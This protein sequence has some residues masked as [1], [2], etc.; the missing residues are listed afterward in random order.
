[1]VQFIHYKFNQLCPLNFVSFFFVKLI[2]LRINRNLSPQ[3]I[4][5]SLHLNRL[6][7]SFSTIKND[8]LYIVFFR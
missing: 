3:I 5:D 4:Q 7:I 6:I 1:M 8:Y 2:N